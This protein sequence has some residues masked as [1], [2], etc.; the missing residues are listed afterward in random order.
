MI[1]GIGTDLARV[2]RLADLWA[3]HGERALDKL[4]A[5]AERAGFADAPDKAR[6]LAKRWAAKE[7]FAKAWGTGIR[8]A[9]TLPS[10][11]VTHDPAGKPG[12]AVSGPVGEALAGLA[13]RC[14]LSLS[15]E[16]DHV[17]AF[18]IV[19]TP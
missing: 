10:I 4:L 18:V 7:A 1:H 8:G 6:Y 9:L 12:L 5:P 15:D 13:A 3:R 2:S 19:E 17:I 16:G 14:H 11:A